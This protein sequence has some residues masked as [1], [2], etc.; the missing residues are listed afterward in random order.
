MALNANDIKFSD[1]YGGNYTQVAVRVWIKDVPAGITLNDA[2]TF[3]TFICAYSTTQNDSGAWIDYQW[4][5]DVDG[6]VVEQVISHQPQSVIEEEVDEEVIPTIEV[7]WPILNEA[8]DVVEAFMDCIEPGAMWSTNYSIHDFDAYMI[9]SIHH[10][11]T[12]DMIYTDATDGSIKLFNLDSEPNSEGLYTNI[13]I[14]PIITDN[15]D[16]NSKPTDM[17]EYNKRVY[18]GYGPD[19][20]PQVVEYKRSSTGVGSYTIAP[21]EHKAPMTA[22]SLED[23]IDK[24]IHLDNL[25]DDD[26]DNWKLG[27][28]LGGNKVYAFKEGSAVI[29]SSENMPFKL[30]AIAPGWVIDDDISSDP[31]SEI[32]DAAYFYAAAYESLNIVR[33]RASITGTAAVGDYALEIII[34]RNIAIKGFTPESDFPEDALIGDI[35]T[36]RSG[37][38]IDAVTTEDMMVISAFREK[39]FGENEP[40]VFI[41]SLIEMEAMYGANT[42]GGFRELLLHHRSIPNNQCTARSPGHYKRYTWYGSVKTNNRHRLYYDESRIKL[43]DTKDWDEAFYN[44]MDMMDKGKESDNTYNG[45]TSTNTISAYTS[46]GDWWASF[47]GGLFSGISDFAYLFLFWNPFVGFFS[48]LTAMGL[49][50]LSHMSCLMS[51]WISGIGTTITNT[52][53]LA[54][55][56]EIL[57]HIQDSL[58]SVAAGDVYFP[59]GYDTGWYSNVSIYIPRLSLFLIHDLDGAEDLYEPYIGLFAHSDADWVKFGGIALYQDDYSG[60]VDL[61]AMGGYKDGQVVT[62]GSFIYTFNHTGWSEDYHQASGVLSSSLGINNLT[63]F[64]PDGVVVAFSDTANATYDGATADADNCY[65]STITG[66]SKLAPQYDFMDGTPRVS[67]QKSIIPIPI[68]ISNQESIQAITL[69]SSFT[70]NYDSMNNQNI[71]LDGLTNGGI[72]TEEC[73]IMTDSRLTTDTDLIVGISYDH[74]DFEAS[75][76]VAL[77]ISIPADIEDIEASMPVEATIDYSQSLL[78]MTSTFDSATTGHAYTSATFTAKTTSTGAK[79]GATGI[80]D[81]ANSGD[82]IIISGATEEA[83]NGRFKVGTSAVDELTLSTYFNLVADAGE[84]IH[85]TKTDKLIDR[86]I[87]FEESLN[88][89]EAFNYEKGLGIIST[90][91]IGYHRYHRKTDTAAAYIQGQWGSNYYVQITPGSESTA[92]HFQ[93]GETY[94]YRIAYLYN[95]AYISALGKGMYFEELEPRGETDVDDADYDAYTSYDS[96]SVQMVINTP[97]PRVTHVMLYRKD[98]EAEY[99]A[100][101]ESAKISR[102]MSTGEGGQYHYTYIDNGDIMGTFEGQTGI[103]ETMARPMVFYEQSTLLGGK[104]FVVNNFVPDNPHDDLS[105][106]LIASKS[107]NFHTFDW[108][109][110]IAILPNIP[111]A[112]T[113]FDGRL[114]VWDDVNTYRIN[115]DTLFIEDT[116]E[117]VGCFDRNS[118]VVTEYGMCF[119]DQNNIYLHNGVTPNPIGAPILSSLESSDFVGWQELKKEKIFVGYDATLNSFVIFFATATGNY[120]EVTESVETIMYEYLDEDGAVVQSET[121]PE[122][123]TQYNTTTVTSENASVSVPVLEYKNLVYNRLTQAWTYSDSEKLSTITQGP[124]GEIYMALPTAIKR[125]AKSSTNTLAWDWDSKEFDFNKAGIVK[126]FSRIIIRGKEMTAAVEDNIAVLIDGTSVDFNIENTNNNLI[127]LKKFSVKKGMTIQLQL[128]NQTGSMESVSLTAKPKKIK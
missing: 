31:T 79:I 103:S 120:E 114:Y 113:A 89:N 59:L 28:S 85:I 21:L 86:P 116:Y 36:Y 12:T 75:D 7:W 27:M 128:R 112:I 73:V 13:E 40:Q 62:L 111:T 69:S 84:T 52:L 8:D 88:T 9:S 47:A 16:L 102:F 3:P 26:N 107:D 49:K 87:L 17:D 24:V 118:F 95:N 37:A 106:T 96:L 32:S 70:N 74:D 71:A 108:A 5:Q 10:E 39:G 60:M 100:E 67:F 18:L 110:D 76:L 121:L 25:I 115:P 101:V 45:V 48:N 126:R 109:N 117:G 1:D 80:G 2:N 6:N 77:K 98:P 105:H 22:A 41:G 72:S 123:G 23:T 43:R 38:N 104:L 65:W 33:A 50:G 68:D 124:S 11:R 53:K 56:A 97:D 58:P 30:A 34:D 127:E 15:A 83:N 63:K 46:S 4:V 64:T 57:S 99:Y 93:K 122:E 61:P 78:N 66:L 119:A 51:A 54:V 19:V 14:Q 55:S 35:V 81:V 125:F 94:K 20:P 29:I 44:Y 42:S 91:N 90:Q 82:V 92:G